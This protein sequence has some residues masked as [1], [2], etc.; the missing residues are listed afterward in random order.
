VLSLIWYNYSNTVQKYSI[1]FKQQFFFIKTLLFLRRISCSFII[2]V[3]I[4]PKGYKYE[5]ENAFNCLTDKRI[6]YFK[7]RLNSRP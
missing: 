1:I 4:R 3:K 7:K 5:A 2:T 6:F